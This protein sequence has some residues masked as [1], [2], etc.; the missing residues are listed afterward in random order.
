MTA[1]A[2]HP[3]PSP[4]RLST[5][6]LLRHEF[7]TPEAIYGTVLITVIIE[8]QED[9]NT[10]WAGLIIA[11][12]TAF[13]FWLA[14]VFAHTVA[15]HGVKRGREIPIATA[16]REAIYHSTGFL[17]GPLVPLLLLA[18][19]PLGVLDDESAYTAAELSS[20]VILF[21]LGALALAERGRRWWA[22]LLGGLLTSGVGV[23]VIILELILH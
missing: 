10:A 13:V 15:R 4:G 19:A 2:A 6:R 1:G 17:T 5:L 14:H 7:V 12:L 8:V 18:L 22:C 11:A 23:L 20:L 16:I 9:E 21:L 3:D